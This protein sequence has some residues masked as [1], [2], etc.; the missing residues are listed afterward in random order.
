MMVLCFGGIG[1]KT[2]TAIQDYLAERAKISYPT[3]WMPTQWA[4]RGN[5]PVERTLSESPFWQPLQVLTVGA[6]RFFPHSVF[7][8][9]CEAESIAHFTCHEVAGT[10]PAENRKWNVLL[11]LAN[12]A[13]HCLTATVCQLRASSLSEDWFVIAMT[14]DAGPAS[15]RRWKL[16]GAS[17]LLVN[18]RDLVALETLLMLE[19]V[20]V[21]RRRSLTPSP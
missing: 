9:T 5:Q 14:D 19:C 4:N 21:N 17:L 16:N 3:D 10:R 18:P 1:T 20:R 13:T 8:G 2:M 15:L 7:Q 11:L 12:S 6:N